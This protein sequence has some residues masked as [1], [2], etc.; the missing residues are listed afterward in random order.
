MTRPHARNKKPGPGQQ[1]A[2]TNSG[3][4]AVFVLAMVMWLLLLSCASLLRSKAVAVR[5][6]VLG[7][8]FVGSKSCVRSRAD[9]AKQGAT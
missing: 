7:Q 4:K 2:T 5:F 3:E 1:A 9:P 6:V 8:S